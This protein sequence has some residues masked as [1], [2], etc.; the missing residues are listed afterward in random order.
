MGQNISVE[1]LGQML[2]A[3]I[4]KVVL[5]ELEPSGLSEAGHQHLI[6]EIAKLREQRDSLADNYN[7]QLGRAGHAEEQLRNLDL[8]YTAQQNQL[9]A[10][11]SELVRLR[12]SHRAAGVVIRSL[13]EKLDCRRCDICLS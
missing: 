13:R 3:E 4:L 1:D 10:R 2:G 7:F 8:C 6:D 12:R 5:P 11:C 9:G